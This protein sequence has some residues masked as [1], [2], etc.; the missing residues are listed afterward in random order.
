MTFIKFSKGF[1]T[2][3]KIEIMAFM[4]VYMERPLPLTLR[5]LL[6]GLDCYLTKNLCAFLKTSLLCILGFSS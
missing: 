4:H 1:V 3:G 2:L 5:G 6:L